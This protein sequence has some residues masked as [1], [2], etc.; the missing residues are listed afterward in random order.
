MINYPPSF[1]NRQSECRSANLPAK[2]FRT[3][4]ES[5]L[6][7]S[8]HFKTIVQETNKTIGL[9]RKIQ[10]HFP[11]APLIT[12]YK[13]LIRPH[14]DYGDMIYDKTFNMSFQQKMKIIQYNAVLSITGVIR[15]SS[16][17]KL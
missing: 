4:L 9:L 3:Y 7:F 14:L 17:E 10:T 16:R 2:T 11:R 15:D 5:K 6:K 8:E 13:S 1:A 12:M